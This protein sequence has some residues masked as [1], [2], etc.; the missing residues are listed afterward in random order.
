MGVLSNTPLREVLEEH[1][2]YWLKVKR[3]ICGTIGSK[4]PVPDL[5][6]YIVDLHPPKQNN[7]PFDHDGVV[8]RNNDITFH[9]RT[10]YDRKVAMLVT[11][12]I[13][14][15]SELIKVSKYT[16]V[17]TDVIDKVLKKEAKSKHRIGV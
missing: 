14:L 9:D 3:K 10:S 15:T 7:I 12:Y 1:R 8:N 11:D 2:N 16:C 4:Y 13:N 5:E 6:V 17:P